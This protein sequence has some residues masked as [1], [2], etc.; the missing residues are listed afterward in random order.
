[1]MPSLYRQT[2]HPRPAS[3][4]PRWLQRLWWWL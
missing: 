1:M 2:Y 3:R 4:V